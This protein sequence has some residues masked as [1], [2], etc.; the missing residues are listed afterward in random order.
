MPLPILALDVDGP[1]ALMGDPDPSVVFE[2]MV[3]GVPFVISRQLPERLRKVP[4]VFQIVW[5]SSWAEGQ[6]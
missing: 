2:G 1:I 3:D 4:A 6:A 5:A